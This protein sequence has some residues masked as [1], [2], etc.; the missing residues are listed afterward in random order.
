MFYLS[1]Y[2]KT[3]AGFGARSKVT[4][5]AECAFA[6]G[7]LGGPLSQRGAKAEL[8]GQ[9][10]LSVVTKI[11]RPR[12]EELPF[13]ASLARLGMQRLEGRGRRIA[14]QQARLCARQSASPKNILR[15][16]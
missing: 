15:A 8:K 3:G 12:P 9:M 14:I 4:F 6:L 11:G 2:R 1:F 5:E 13:Q 10:R 7:S 16:R